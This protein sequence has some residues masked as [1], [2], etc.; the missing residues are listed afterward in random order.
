MDFAR[1]PAALA[2]ALRSGAPSLMPLDFALH[3][4]EVALAV[5]AQFNRGAAVDYRPQTRFD[6]LPLMSEPVL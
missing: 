6:P 4:N 3:V 5:H 2:L 1:G